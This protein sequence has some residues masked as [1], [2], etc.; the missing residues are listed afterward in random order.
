MLTAGTPKVT[1][2]AEVNPL[3]IENKIIRRKTVLELTS[4]LNSSR[5]QPVSLSIVKNRFRS[6][7]RMEEGFIIIKKSLLRKFN[8]QP[9]PQKKHSYGQKVITT[10][11]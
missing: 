8:K 7:G 11:H 5:Y 9:P 4:E 2:P 3:L 1:I 10:E 6:V